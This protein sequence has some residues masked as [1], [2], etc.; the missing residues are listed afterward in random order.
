MI[1]G[2]EFTIN[3]NSDH[4][5]SDTTFLFLRFYDFTFPI[6]PRSCSLM[7]Y[8]SEDDV[9]AV[10]P[11]RFNGADEELAAVGVLARIGHA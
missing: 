9:S 2:R 4:Y 6:S 3:H 11:G 5:K 10:Q 8:L 1:F 7:P